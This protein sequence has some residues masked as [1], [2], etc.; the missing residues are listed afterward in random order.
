LILGKRG[1]LKKGWWILPAVT[2]AI[3]AGDQASKYAVT[4]RLALYEA[5]VPIPELADWFKIHYVANTGAVFG[6]FQNGASFFAVISIAVSLAILFYYL[7]LPDGQSLVRFSLALQLGGALGNLIDRLLLGYVVDF[8]D[9]YIW[10][11]FNIADMSVVCGAV[12]LAL[13]LLREDWQERK[14]AR[15]SE[16]VGERV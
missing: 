3:L 9:F 1:V 10:P 7:F 15:A 16:K 4:S 6:L 11:V 8:L 5:W 13:L 2:V 12:L 14:K